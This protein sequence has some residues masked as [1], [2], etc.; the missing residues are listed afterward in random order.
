M[1][2]VAVALIA[3]AGF[4]QQRRDTVR[5]RDTTDTRDRVDDLNADAVKGG[6][7]PGSFV[8][9]GTE[10]SLAIGGFIKAVGFY[11]SDASDRGRESFRECCE[12]T[13]VAAERVNASGPREG[14]P[15]RVSSGVAGE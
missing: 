13:R 4:A 15:V 7:F 2:V 8:I 10:V 12:R 6:V 14:R 1:F 9:P 5:A 3:S 11:D